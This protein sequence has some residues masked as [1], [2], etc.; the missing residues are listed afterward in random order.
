MLG[1]ILARL[2][3]TIVA[4]PRRVL[5][6]SGLA[7]MLGLALG[8]QVEFRTSRQELAPPG[9]PDQERWTALLEEVGS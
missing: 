6:Y 3:D 2:H 9:D 4:R 5:L 1:R 7:V 8:Y